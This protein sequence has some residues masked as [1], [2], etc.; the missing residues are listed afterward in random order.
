MP[1]ASDPN[2]SKQAP[3]RLESHD[4]PTQLASP[5]QT[6][7]S[8]ESPPP[9]VPLPFPFVSISLAPISSP[10]ASSPST[11]P[12]T[13]PPK[14][15][16]NAILSCNPLPPKSTHLHASQH[17]PRLDSPPILPTSLITLP[18]L[19]SIS[20]L[21]RRFDSSRRIDT[22][23]HFKGAWTHLTAGSARMVGRAARLEG[24]TG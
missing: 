8:L 1:F 23:R 15:L 4:S 11:H 18:R 22:A 3:A 19:D 16:P 21:A 10:P 24:R 5:L 17:P 20:P 14:R 6:K 2:P 7:H 12:P 13:Q 9:F